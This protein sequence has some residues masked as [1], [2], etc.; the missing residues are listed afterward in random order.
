[1]PSEEEKQACRQRVP[2]GRGSRDG[3]HTVSTAASERQH[4]HS[5]INP[6]QATKVRSVGLAE[7]VRVVAS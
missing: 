4:A 6:I 1:M 7:A 5:A 2:E 3:V